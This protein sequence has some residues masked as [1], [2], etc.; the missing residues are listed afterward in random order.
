V[1]ARVTLGQRK[2]EP[3][4]PQLTTGRPASPF[5]RSP[6]SPLPHLLEVCHDRSRS[7]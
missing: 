1:T 5:V 7:R 4:D 6:S 3:P 2:C